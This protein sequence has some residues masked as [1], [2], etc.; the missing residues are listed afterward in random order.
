[1]AV[2]VIDVVDGDNHDVRA[3]SR[4]PCT[5]TCIPFLLVVRTRTRSL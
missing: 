5:C 2:A 4:P 3:P 1:M